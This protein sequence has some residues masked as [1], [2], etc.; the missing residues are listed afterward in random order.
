MTER[1]R[2]A[3][4]G[5]EL[6]FHREM[7]EQELVRSGLPVD[8]AKA[9]ARRALGSVPLAHDQ[10]RDVWIARW[11]QDISYDVRFAVRILVKDRRFAAAAVLALALGIAV[12]NT[13]FTL[14]NTAVLKDV[15]FD[16]PDRLV[17]IRS[18]DARAREAG[19]SRLDFDDWR[20][21][22][23]AFAGMAAVAGGAMNIADDAN[24]PDRIRG[25]HISV[26]AFKLLRVRPVIGRDFV[27]ADDLPGASPVVMLG[28]GLWQRRY[29]GDRAILGRMVRVNDVPAS[30]IGVM[31]A[32][33]R[34]PFSDEAWQPLSLAAGI[35]TARRDSRS[36]FVFARLADSLTMDQ[37]RS[38]LTTIMQRIEREH[39][40]TNQGIA[41]NLSSMND[42]MRGTELIFGT[43]MGSV[44]FVLLIA[45]ANVANLQ[46]ARVA[47]RARE[48]AIRASL[49]ATRW[50]I[51][52]Q[53]LIE[54]AF[55]A[56]IAG[57]LGMALS[58]FGVR[59][60]GVAFNGRQPD[61]PASAAA[62]P[63]W[64]DFSM[65]DTVFLFV[66]VAC[67]AATLLTGL[68]PA[69]HAARTN[70]NDVLKEGGRGVSSGARTWTS[71]FMIAQVALALVLLTGAGLMVR[72]FVN[73]Y[74]TNRVI[75]TAGLFT[76]RLS[77]PAQKYPSP[78][79]RRMFFER[80]DAR[81]SAS[82]LV[83][84]FAIA[85]HIPFT[86]I[87]STRLVAIEGEPQESIDR[88]PTVS[89]VYAG[90]QYFE[91]LGLRMVRG[92]GFVAG[93]GRPGQEGVVINA[94]AAQMFFAD[95]DSIGKR[96]RL[97]MPGAAT[98]SPPFHTIIG[99][100]PNIPQSVGTQ[101]PD[102][103][104]VFLPLHG[105]A[106][107]N[108]VSLFVRARADISS[109]I[110]LVR[111][112]VRALDSNLPV[113]YVQ[114]LEEVF[115]DTRQPVRIIGSWFSTLAVIA[116][117]L[118]AVGLYAITGHA[119]TQRTREVGV[120]IALG[121]HAGDVVWIFLRRT[122][123]QLGIGLTIGIA[124]AVALTQLLKSTPFVD[125]TDPTDLTTLLIVTVVLI[126][127][128][129]VATL[130]PVRRATRIDPIVA[131]R[132]E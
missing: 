18:R 99:V 4:L 29:G 57:L 21:S 51:V 26:D 45:C 56:L 89:H 64:A 27:A 85:S 98:T 69:L 110:A 37:A 95:G 79:T 76:A 14:I 132:Y 73:L 54:C 20:D 75:D 25:A 7:K 50:R 100:A 58:V 32:D 129:I 111:E 131:L 10:T 9:G 94:R 48:L 35:R 39:P 113:Y 13:I 72:S 67:L 28:Y 116:L 87:L 120:R 84:D 121:A 53:L 52:R 63:Y 42:R 83:S 97:V 105:E 17:V 130:V 104:T 92:R 82:P 103:P 6:E 96:I 91:T 112:E 86:P 68:A 36:L 11:V 44:L 41:L 109:A 125:R 43:L 61:A 128:A 118:A 30:V 108:V 5:E 77:L 8:R 124:A 31:P 80:L 115:A 22:T 33:F 46:M 119:V 16:E 49:G 3:E 38:D 12:T 106:T 62:V 70:T 2:H 1:R 114:T 126:A 47:G 93:D 60:L 24:I 59:F 40:D 78:D 19:V 74:R 71:A 107:P 66:A 90:A 123:A 102:R 122:F 117:L 127:A 34:F 23:R 55:V 88:L 101:I 15:P 65:N 81:L